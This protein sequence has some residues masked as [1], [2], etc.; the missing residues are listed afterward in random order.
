MDL[1]FSDFLLQLDHTF[2]PQASLSVQ[3]S[4]VFGGIPAPNFQ[5]SMQ[6]VSA[7]YGLGPG[8][9]FNAAAFSGDLNGAVNFSE[10]PKKV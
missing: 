5:P 2:I 8:A 9:S 3:P 1:L 7:S 4:P 10:R 6:P